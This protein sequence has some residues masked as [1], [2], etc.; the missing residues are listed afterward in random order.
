MIQSEIVN[1][2]SEDSIPIIQTSKIPICYHCKQNG[3]VIKN[4]PLIPRK[5]SLGKEPVHLFLKGSLGLPLENMP[6]VEQSP[7]EAEIT[8]DFL[9]CSLCSKFLDN[10]V[11]IPCCGSSYCENC[12]QDYLIDHEFKCP[13]CRKNM[14][15]EDLI[16]NI[17]LRKSV[18]TF[19]GQR[20]PKPVRISYFYITNC[21]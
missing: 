12:I 14:S 1:Q 21:S 6:P 7:T 16:A 18:A 10:A 3:H 4:C 5:A 9:C 17:S 13:S 19:Q 2:A 20:F 8:P 15:P 11:L